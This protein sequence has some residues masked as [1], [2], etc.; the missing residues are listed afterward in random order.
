MTASPPD[1]TVVIPTLDEGEGLAHLL[2]QLGQVRDIVLD[3]VVSDGGSTDDTV[4][5]ARS[6]GARVVRGPPGRGQQLNR[7]RRAARAPTLL[8]LHADSRLTTPTQ[9]AD[10]L[11]VFQH[12]VLR[13]DGRAAGHFQLC[14]HDARGPAFTY[15]EALSALGRAQTVNGDQG[16]LVTASWFDALGGFDPTMAFLEDQDFGA[17]VWAQGTWV[18]LPGRLQTSARR[19]LS[20]GV[21]ERSIHNA[22]IMAFFHIRNPRSAQ[23]SVVG[24]RVQSRSRM[25][26]VGPLAGAVARLLKAEP[27][28]VLPLA[29]YVNR[30]ALW[31]AAF[32]LDVRAHGPK[33]AGHHPRLDAYD[34]LVAP[35]MHNALGDACCVGPMLLTAAMVGVTY[36]A[37]EAR[38]ASTPAGEAVG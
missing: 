3:V 23:A 9:L 5:L 33:A 4:A 25:L 38:A 6:H 27:E 35:L 24:Y 17:R 21:A 31:R 19:F 14:F 1:L 37:R 26:S 18:L 34:R 8:F 36:A 16:L 22:V 2:V 32:W 7:G 28:L 11:R 12:A 10:A 20:E 13:H 30:H 15:Y 29:Q